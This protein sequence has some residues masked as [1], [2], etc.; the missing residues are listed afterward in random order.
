MVGF[1]IWIVN[2]KSACYNYINNFF[3][4]YLFYEWLFIKLKV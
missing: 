2:D 3:G 1:L 4:G